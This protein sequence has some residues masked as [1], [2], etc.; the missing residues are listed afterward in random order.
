[1]KCVCC[2]FPFP[3]IQGGVG[4]GIQSIVHR[5]RQHT[6]VEFWASEVIPDLKKSSA[7]I[8]GW[9]FFLTA[10]LNRGFNATY[11]AVECK[12]GC[13]SG[14]DQVQCMNRQCACPLGFFGPNCNTEMCPK[15]CSAHSGHG[16]CDMVGVDILQVLVVV[17]MYWVFYL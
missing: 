15:N 3:L 9:F 13:R 4:K 12:G 10:H 2:K 8:F 17:K 1:M 7:D 5:F 16:R 11:K 14:L 6:W